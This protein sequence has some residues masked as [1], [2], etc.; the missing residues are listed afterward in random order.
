MGPRDVIN[1]RFGRKQWWRERD[2]N[3]GR[4]AQRLEI[5]HDVLDFARREPKQRHAGMDSL[6]QGSLQ[7]CNGILETQ[8]TKRGSV[9]KRTFAVLVDAVALRAM[10][11]NKSQTP[12]FRGRLFRESG[13]TC[14]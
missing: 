13:F 9:R 6:R 12:S 14:K 4:S 1:S 3:A 2:P 8:G 10:H 11:A 5:G 7:V